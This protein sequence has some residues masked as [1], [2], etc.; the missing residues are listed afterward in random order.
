MCDPKP[1]LS[2]CHT[3]WGRVGT[4]KSTAD[5]QNDGASNGP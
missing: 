1:P 4:A 3:L 5:V 2:V